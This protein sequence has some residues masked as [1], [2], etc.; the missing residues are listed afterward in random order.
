MDRTQTSGCFSG[1]KFW[2][3]DIWL[4][5]EFRTSLHRSL[6][7]NRW[8]S[9]QNH[10]QTLT[11][12]NL[13]IGGRI[14]LSYGTCHAVLR[15]HLTMGNGSFSGVKR[16]GCGIDHPPPS[17][18][19]VKERVELYLFC[20]SGPSWPVLWWILPLPS[21]QLWSVWEVVGWSALALWNC[22][23][24]CPTV[25]LIEKFGYQ[26]WNSSV[27]ATLKYLWAS[28]SILLLPTFTL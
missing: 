19:A 21:L 18:A 27:K 12:N 3:K 16:L 13:E 17:S 15:E 5:W 23:R 7:L 28:S 1:L 22:C 14:V 10:Q 20:P 26:V 2:G 25:F 24:A 11:K 4:I 8:G 9:S 6:E